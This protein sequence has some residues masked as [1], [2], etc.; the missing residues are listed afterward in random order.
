MRPYLFIL[1][2]IF[3]IHGRGQT[4]YTPPAMSFIQSATEIIIDTS[5]QNVPISTIQS[6]INSIRLNN[7]TAI[8]RVN[9]SGVFVITNASLQLSNNMILFLRDCV[10][11]NDVNS[12][13]GSMISISGSSNIGISGTD[14]SYFD[15]NNVTGVKG[16]A[17][18]GSGKVHLDH[19]NFKNCNGGGIAYTGNGLLIYA[20]A[21]SITRCTVS[22]CGSIGISIANAFNFI[23]SDNLIQNCSTGFLLNA[24]NT[25]LTNNL[26]SNC[27]TGVQVASDYCALTYNVINNCGTAIVLNSTSNETAIAYNN[28]KSNAVGVVANGTKARIYYND[29]DN[30]AEVTSSGSGNHLFCNK[31]IT[32]AEGNVTGCIYFNPPLIGNQHNDLIKIGKGRTDI[33]IN[34]GILSNV[35]SALDAAHAAQPGNV[36][37]AKLT[38]EFITSPANTDSLV[39]KEDECILLL[40][41]IA[42]TDTSNRVIIFKENSIVSFSGGT[43]NGNSTNGKT[44]L[45]YISGISGSNSPTVVLDSINLN[46]S[47]AEGIAKKSNSGVLYVRACNIANSLRRGIWQ[48]ATSRLIAFQNNISNSTMDGI[49]LDAFSSYALVVKNT[50]TYNTR[51]GVFIEEGASNHIVLGNTLN[52][53]QRGISFYNLAVANNYS[54]KNLLAF[55]ICNY[56][57]RGIHFD[58]K[59]SDRATIDNFIFNNTCNNNSDVGFGGLYKDTTTFN[60]YLALNTVESNTN[61]PFANGAVLNVN[62]VWNL[63]S[64]SRLTISVSQLSSFGGIAAGARSS[65]KSFSINGINLVDDVNVSAPIN[66]LVSIDDVN[67]FS[68]VIAK[69]TNGLVSAII[70]VKYAPTGS[71]SNT[72]LLTIGSEGLKNQYVSVSGFLNT[73]YYKGTGSLAAT[74]NWS[75]TADGIGSNTP[76]F[77]DSAI[78]YKILHDAITDAVLNISN[79]SISP[80][81]IVVGD[82]ISNA[83]KL[84]VT[85]GYPINGLIEISAALNGNN[86][87]CWQDSIASPSLGK[88]HFTSEVIFKKGVHAL[89]TNNVSFGKLTIESPI[90]EH[91]KFSGKVEIQNSLV[92]N[93]GATLLFDQSANNYIAIKSG[94]TVTINGWIKSAKQAGIFNF[95]AAVPSV[96]GGSLQFEELEPALTISKGATI[97]YNRSIL[98]DNQLI[99][100]LPS[101]ISF[102]N[103]VITDSGVGHSSSKQLATSK[104]LVAGNLSIQQN[105][106]SSIDFSNAT[107][108]K[109]GSNGTLNIAA[110]NNAQINAAGKLLINPGGSIIG[111]YDQIIGNVTIQQQI[112]GQRAY[113]IFSNPFKT[114]QVQTDLSVN[115]AINVNGPY[116]A[117][118]YDVNSNLWRPVTS[119]STYFNEVYAL[120]IRGLNSDLLA[121]NG[122]GLV[123]NAGPTSFVYNVSGLLNSA[124]VNIS[125]TPSVSKFLMVGNPFVGNISSTTLTGRTKVPYYVYKTNVNNTS[126]RVRSGGWV[127]QNTETNVPALGV[128]TYMPVTSNSFI[129]STADILSN[130]NSISGIFRP[131]NED[132]QIEFDL[133]KQDNFQDKLFFS[134]NSQAIESGAD[135]YDLNKIRNDAANFYTL[136]D[137]TVE[138]AVNSTNK[139]KNKIPIGIDGPTGIYSFKL[140]NNSLPPNIKL[141][142]RDNFLK[143]DLELKGDLQYSFE[144]NDNVLSKGNSRFEL[145]LKSQQLLVNVG[146]EITYKCYGT[147]VKDH[148][149]IQ[150]EG[151]INKVNISLYDVQGRKIQTIRAASNYN[152]INVSMLSAGIY[153]LEVSNGTKKLVIKFIKEN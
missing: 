62:P 21:G 24:N 61:G 99:S 124:S 28:I 58:A 113:R 60:N 122:S 79:F 139:L 88:L 49:D 35:R 84:I 66:Y 125:T 143:A 131:I 121:G 140:V 57:V 5:F 127:P 118:L 39:I 148:I 51:H 87:L 2:F 30:V 115:N 50:C 41:S 123:Y 91:V 48:L 65:N 44:G 74:S 151:L 59:L 52:Y 93:T 102:S 120:F 141:Y 82:S 103:L 6:A 133:Y 145:N 75:G 76:I 15:G 90:S 112:S 94:A 142:L 134:Y 106:G 33:T 55:N 47:R 69:Q 104:F 116:D 101:S 42:G 37:V 8:I 72:G 56:N 135:P 126:A 132:Q 1:L 100:A 97:E 81:R 26:F 86:S 80:S 78:T 25:A 114:G 64:N 147:I 54:S 71:G 11:R 95:G 129:L 46:N 92:V 73:F 22:N 12:T 150:L 68:T 96:N 4:F 63:L 109:I 137:D 13:V 130:S 40:G 20:D 10:I 89:F 34:S 107:Y 152:E 146:N 117:K 67:Y 19:L 153:F 144:I 119:S 128:L 136:K 38:G 16:V 17:I 53:N 83:V 32:V 18:S 43:I 9:M 138:L 27:T 14:S 111:N 77:S 85:N 45:I 70:Y 3:S 98:G 108:L 23:C 105:G 149:L 36:I 7:P 29:C 31:G 110:D